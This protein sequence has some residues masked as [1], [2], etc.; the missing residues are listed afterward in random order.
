MDTIT[1]LL[2]VLGLYIL[3]YVVAKYIGF[4]K[5]SEKGIEANFP[6]FLMWKTERLN[7]IL[8]RLG[9]K[10][11]RIFFTIGIVVGYGGLIFAFWLFGDNLLK[12]F[13]QPEAAGG[14]VPIIPGI[15]VTGL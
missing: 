2:I 6:L 15:T 8:T 10:F 1:V 4:E 5:L 12:F 3:I 11:P 7:A 14:V 9:K 13:I